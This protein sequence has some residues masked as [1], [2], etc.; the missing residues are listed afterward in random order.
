MAKQK[1][2][3]ASFFS[4][5]NRRILSWIGGALVAVAVGLWTV[6]VYFDERGSDKNKGQKAD[7]GVVIGRDAIGNNIVNQ[8]K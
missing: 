1:A 4:V 6:F 3:A 8:Q 5:E 2:A 7:H